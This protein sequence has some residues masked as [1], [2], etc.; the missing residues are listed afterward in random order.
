VPPQYGPPGQYEPP[1]QQGGGAPYGGGPGR[2]AAPPQHSGPPQPPYNGQQPYGGQPPHGGQPGY[3]PPAGFG[4]PPPYLRNQPPRQRRSGL[5]LVFSLLGALVLIV[6]IG[7]VA[8][9]SGGDS[10]AAP[11]PTDST[12]PTIPAPSTAPSAPSSSSAPSTTPPS[13]PPT[14]RTVQPTNK[15][16]VTQNKLYV[17]GLL[18]ASRCRE[19]SAR[20]T[21]RANVLKYYGQSLA[22]LNKVWRPTVLETRNAFRA[23][24]LVVYMGLSTTS[25]CGPINGAVYCSG[26]ETIYMSATEDMDN[27][28]KASKIWTRTDM[29]FTIAHEYGHHVQMLTGILQASHTREYDMTNRDLRLEESRRLELQASCLSAVY[30][31]A[32]KAFFPVSGEWARWWR[33]KVANHGDQWNP[34]RD[35]GDKKN[36]AWWSMRGFNSKNPGLCNTFT[37]TRKTVS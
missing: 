26:N 11:N 4:G 30:L 28:R 33:W 7:I 20:P 8:L 9:T 16:I 36:H 21:S 29:A 18:P 15:Q 37:A 12:L 14:R 32:D 35:H 24:R 17:T 19:P 27:Y 22:C 13:P 3:G 34:Q 25:P 10:T 5:V 31:G 1:P 2:H 6:T 23:P